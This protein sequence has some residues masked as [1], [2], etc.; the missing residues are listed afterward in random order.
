[1]LMSDYLDGQL[2]QKEQQAIKEHLAHCPECFTL[3]KELQTQRTLFQNAK[4]QEV[5]LGLWQSIQNKIIAERLA[6]E[7]NKN[8]GI[9]WRLREL[10]LAPKPVFALSSAI[11]AIILI[12]TFTG[13][14]VQRKKSFVKA[15][16]GESILDYSLNSPRDDLF[17]T[18]GTNIE[19]YFL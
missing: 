12:A 9:L 2:S 8:A 16:F 18:L 19:E 14:I 11:L 13:G 10:I 5:P 17:S 6:Q 4:Q 15:N 1:M 3:E 7:S